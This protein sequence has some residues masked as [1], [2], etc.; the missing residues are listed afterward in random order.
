MNFK[1]KGNV[2]AIQYDGNNYYIIMDML[3]EHCIIDNKKEMVKNTLYINCVNGK[4]YIKL[5]YIELL[6][7]EWLVISECG[8]PFILTNKQFKKTFSIVKDTTK[9][10]I[11]A[12]SKRGK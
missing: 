7:N 3:M 2:K 6:K 8:E 12:K 10:A 5:G 11:T 9:Q 4:I 1:R